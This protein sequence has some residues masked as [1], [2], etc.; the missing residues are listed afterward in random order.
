MRE[1]LTLLLLTLVLGGSLSHAAPTPKTTLP[2]T[3]YEDEYDPSLVAIPKEE[4]EFEARYFLTLGGGFAGGNYLESSSYFQGPYFTLRFLPV[5]KRQ[6]VWD[7]VFELHQDDIFSLGLGRRWYCCPDD[8]FLPYARLAA[9]IVFNPKDEIAGLAEIRRWRLHAAVG[10]GKSFTTE[11]GVGL[12]VT[13]PDLYIL[14]GYNF[15]F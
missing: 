9:N 8:P 11:I 1:S 2:S 12:A 10:L 6:L 7:Y 4:Q 3:S 13:G 5:E 15:G 14:L